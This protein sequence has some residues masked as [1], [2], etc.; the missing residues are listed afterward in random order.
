MIGWLIIIGVLIFL[1]FLVKIEHGFKRGKI[2]F[3]VVILALILLSFFVLV[4]THNAQL[5]S[6]KA[7]VNTVYLYFTWIGEKGVQIFD[8]G[9]T[10]VNMVGNVIK[11]TKN[12]TLAGYDGRK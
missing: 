2:I 3:Y 4:R 9:K 1:L 5:D 7:V 12:Q 8:V 6:P 10:T 11:G